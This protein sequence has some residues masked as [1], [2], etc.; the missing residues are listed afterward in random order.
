MASLPLKGSTR[1]TRAFT[2][3]LNAALFR[4]KD[5]PD[6]KPDYGLKTTSFDRSASSA[7]DYPF[8]L[9]VYLENISAG[10]YGKM[11]PVTTIIPVK[12]LIGGTVKVVRTDAKTEC[13][14]SLMMKDVS[15]APNALMLPKASDIE[16]VRRGLV[17][18]AYSGAFDLCDGTNSEPAPKGQACRLHHWRLRG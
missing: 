6:S 15:F 10:A 7:G 18:V 16:V 9:S 17:N 2:L 11:V 14:G 13:A 8:E 12:G 3:D 1:Y 5:A 4:S